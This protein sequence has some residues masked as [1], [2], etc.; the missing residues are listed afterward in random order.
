MDHIKER[1]E[2]PKE[3][4]WNLERIFKTD[5]EFQKEIKAVR[6]QIDEFAKLEGH[7]TENAKTFYR[8]I[9]AGN[10]IE[11]RLNKLYTYAS[12]KSDEDVANTEN[13]AKKEQVVNLYN[14]ASSKMYFQT[15]ELLNTEKE[16]IDIDINHIRFLRKKKNFYPI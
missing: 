13:Q 16:V 14:Y 9:T 4:Q 2:V 15:P 1:R 3:F 11:R 10:E 8:S 12:M 5:E 7:T 6:K